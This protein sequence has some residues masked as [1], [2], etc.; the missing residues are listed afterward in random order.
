M[1][2]DAELERDARREPVGGG[3]GRADDA[4]RHSHPMAADG[5][6]AALL[7]AFIAA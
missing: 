2:L 3:C 6:L 5:P 1:E 7:G 4:R